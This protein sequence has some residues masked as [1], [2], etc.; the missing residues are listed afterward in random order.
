MSIIAYCAIL[1]SVILYHHAVLYSIVAH[2][3]TLISIVMQSFTHV[4]CFGNICIGI[5]PHL[6]SYF[7]LLF[8]PLHCDVALINE[9]IELSFLTEMWNVAF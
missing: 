9:L 7:Q 6:P 4:V 3:N 8:N 5:D 1:C 2:P